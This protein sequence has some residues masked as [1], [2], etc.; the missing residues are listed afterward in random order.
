LNGNREDVEQGQVDGSVHVVIYFQLHEQNAS[1][2]LLLFFVVVVVV[3][4]VVMV[5]R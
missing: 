3:I 1:L 4:V 2:F 5:Q